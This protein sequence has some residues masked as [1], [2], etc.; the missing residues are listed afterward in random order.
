MKKTGK[1]YEKLVRDI[2]QRALFLD[3]VEKSA[4]SF[5][6]NLPG[7]TKD[8]N[9]TP[10]L[11][12]IDVMWEFEMAGVFHQ[13]VVQAKDW[14]SRVKKEQ[15]LTFKSVLDDLPGQP[16]G[17]MVTRGGYQAGAKFYAREHGIELYELRSPQKSVVSF[18]D[19]GSDFNT[20]VT[21]VA[22][23]FEPSWLSA[24][25]GDL[26]SIMRDFDPAVA[27][28]YA[29]RDGSLITPGRKFSTAVDNIETASILSGVQ[30][31]AL[32]YFDEPVAL[33][34]PPMKE[35]AMI[36]GVSG[37][38]AVTDRELQTTSVDLAQLFS[39]ILKK[40]AD[41]KTFFIDQ[42]LDR[43]EALDECGLCDFCCIPIPLDN[44]NVFFCKRCVIVAQKQDG[45]RNCTFVIDEGGWGACLP[46][47]GMISGG[48]RIGLFNRAAQLI[49]RGASKGELQSIEMLQ[50]GFWLGYADLQ[51]IAI[52]S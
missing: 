23:Q 34:N 5:D 49:G 7:K 17:I 6:V 29:V 50:N 42:M 44:S 11:H 41:G 36:M 52:Q 40:V 22:L 10:I 43:V 9:G 20:Y 14:K 2:F 26:K 25:R 8:C 16:R 3:G 31:V 48:D 12:Q 33:W 18:S 4:I 37:R 24:K 28:L 30:D 15:V 45:S 27:K 47:A 46:C 51:P 38:L 35:H 1:E 13:V 39:Y 21:D 32:N 19:T